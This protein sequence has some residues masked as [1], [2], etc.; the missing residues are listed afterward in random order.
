ML[1]ASKH[2][3]HSTKHGDEYDIMGVKGSEAKTRRN[4]L[5]APSLHHLSVRL[6]L[7]QPNL[8]RIDISLL[9]SLTLKLT[10][11]HHVC[12]KS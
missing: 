10:L 9:F 1:A 8:F 2:T 3:A 4:A 6:A 5:A 11:H 12:Q 7:N